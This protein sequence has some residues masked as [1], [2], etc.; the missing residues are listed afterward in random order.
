[1]GTAGKPEADMLKQTAGVN[2]PAL[3]HRHR[4]LVIEDSEDIRYLLTALLQDR[5]EVLATAAGEPGLAL[6]RSDERPDII[7]LAITS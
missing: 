2:A 4:I 3:P 6:A 5:Y 7:L 1:M